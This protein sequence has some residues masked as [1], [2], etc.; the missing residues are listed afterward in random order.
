VARGVWVL[1][2]MV[3]AVFDVPCTPQSI[4]RKSSSNESAYDEGEPVFP[5]RSGMFST[6][7]YIQV[8]D[9]FEEQ[10]KRKIQQR[11]SEKSHQDS[12]QTPPNRKTRIGTRS[13][14]TP[15]AAI[16]S[17][18]TDRSDKTIRNGR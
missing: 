7:L 9:R 2:E 5:V 15:P 11:R 18:Y 3:Q 14:T 12:L 4:G 13:G 16:D 8:G 17:V 10:L 6:R 1:N